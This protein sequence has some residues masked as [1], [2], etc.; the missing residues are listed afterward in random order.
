F[1]ADLFRRPDAA[2]IA[3]RLAHQGELR[4]VIAADRNARGMDLGVTGIRHGRAALVGAPDGRA[5]RT[6]RVRRKIEDIAVTAGA[7]DHGVRQVRFH[8]AGDKIANHDAAGFAVDY[9]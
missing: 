9:D 4:L 1:V 6:L 8:F 3:E 7:E 2:V 5:V